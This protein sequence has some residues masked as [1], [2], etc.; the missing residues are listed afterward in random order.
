M[1]A[2]LKKRF[3]GKVRKAQGCW[4]WQAC[5][6]DAGYGIFGVQNKRID[7]AHRIS[8]RLA[9]GEIPA[10]M[11]VCHKCDNRKCVKP[12]HLFLGTNQD[13]VADMIAKGRNSTPPP[14]GGWNRYSYSAEVIALLGA[15]PDTEIARQVGVTK[16]AIQRER[17]RRGIPALQSQTRFKKGDPHPRWDRDGG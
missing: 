7:R 13:N 15:K 8:F 12:S 10:G 14:M 2:D 11:F 17:K 6:N 3:W 9:K 16:Y 4:E 5:V 1:N